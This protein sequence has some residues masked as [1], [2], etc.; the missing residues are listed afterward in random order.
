MNGAGSGYASVT[1]L[2]SSLYGYYSGN[3]PM[4]EGMVLEHTLS[5]VGDESLEPLTLNGLSP[6]ATTGAGASFV[7]YEDGGAP[8]DTMARVFTACLE[9]SWTYETHT[10][11][12]EGGEVTFELYLGVNLVATAPGAFVK[13]SGTLDGVAFEE[14]DYF[15]LYYRPDHH[16]F[17]RHFA[18]RFD[19]PIGAA[20][21]LRVEGV[22]PYTADPPAATISLADCDL[23][24]LESRSFLSQSMTTG[25]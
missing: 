21:A 15:Q 22:V 7:L 9:P 1:D 25:G 3:Q 6:D 23:S 14:T 19:S 18:L 20:C 13:A 10:V 4:T 12:F 11:V 17:G 2:G 16:H 8:Y 24:V 5:I